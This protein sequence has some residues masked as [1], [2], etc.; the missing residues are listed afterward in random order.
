M[1][2]PTRSTLPLV[3]ILVIGGGGR[4]HAIVLALSRD[5]SVTALACA[6]GNAGTAALAETYGVDVTKPAEVT[7]LATKWK[8]DLVVFGPETPLVAGAADAVQ[9][10][11]FA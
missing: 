10:A 2:R 9:A 5:P 11:G 4:E 6:P 3:R 8:A 7:E 1:W